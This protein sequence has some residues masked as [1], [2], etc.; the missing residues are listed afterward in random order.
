MT[1]MRLLII[2]RVDEQLPLLIFYRRV[3]H[4]QGELRQEEEEQAVTGGRGRGG[5]GRGGTGRSGG[6]RHVRRQRLK[7]VRVRLHVP[8][9]PVGDLLAK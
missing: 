9:L 6:V 4:A 3:R 7:S 1:D 2:E 5:A 8:M